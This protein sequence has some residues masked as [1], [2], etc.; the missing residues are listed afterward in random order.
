MV[1]RVIVHKGSYHDSAF[2]MR[3]SREMAGMSGVVDAVALMGT[4]LNRE[5]L[6]RNGYSGHELDQ[7]T[8]VDL[9]VAIRAES[10][11]A[12]VEAEEELQRLLE[13]ASLTSADSSTDSRFASLEAALEAHTETNLVSVA[14][15]GTYAAYV[16]HRALDAGKHVFLFSNNVPIEEEINLKKRALELGLLVMGPDC[17]T[18]MLSTV[19][20]GFAN[21]VR[22]GRVGLVGASGT[23]I[24]EV[25]CLV[26][27]L[28]FGISHAI[29]TG[30][31][32]LSAEVGGLMTEF[33]LDLL[34]EDQGTQVIVLVAKHPDE[35]VA[36]R[37]QKKMTGMEKSV[38]VRYLGQPPRNSLPGVVYAASLDEAACEAVSLLPEAETGMED[39]F[40]DLDQDARAIL[41]SRGLAEGR[42]IGLFGG[43]SLASEAALVLGQAGLSVAVPDR[44]LGVEGGVEGTG[45][46]IVDAGDDFYT[47]GKPHPMVDQTVRCDLIRGVAADPGVGVLL[48]DLVLGDGVHPDP[49]PELVQAIEA[50]RTQRGRSQVLVI[51]SV[52][53]TGL[54]PQDTE[55]Q[56]RLLASAGI[57]V[58]PSA[59]RAARLAA[60]VCGGGH[61]A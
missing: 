32:D 21:R 14:V 42:L 27:A 25:S 48:L 16:A 54:D 47:V 13:A 4:V 45:H 57:H 8:P 30:S 36:A 35:S 60:T 61:G 7:A 37:L 6:E 26:H 2:L 33:G 55:R 39:P 28:G 53:G 19:G 11:E 49:A 5:L 24:Q 44:P 51:A 46:L 23:G 38:V 22:P 10:N 41:G 56:R 34:A 20:L 31:A 58:Q 15:P 43:G 18:A 59:A 1:E 29:G 3:V 12:S 52:T 50:G 17:G 9:L 40:C